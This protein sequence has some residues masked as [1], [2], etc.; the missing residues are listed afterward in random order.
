MSSV[1]LK[2][3]E[4]IENARAIIAQRFKEDYHHIGSALRTKSGKVFSAVHLEAYVGRVAVCAEA[5]AIGMAAAAGDT[6]LEA[7]VAVDRQGRVVSPCGICRELISDYSPDC[8]VIT[9]ETESMNI[10]ELL[11]RKYR[12]TDMRKTEI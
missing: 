3:R 1:Q 12:R 9:T 10:R 6:E 5:I 7:I 8:K 4:L 11:P 2:D